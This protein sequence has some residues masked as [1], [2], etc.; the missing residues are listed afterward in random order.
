VSGFINTA[1]VPI[2]SKLDRSYIEFLRLNCPSRLLSPY[3]AWEDERDV[4]DAVGQF[5]AS[6]KRTASQKQFCPTGTRYRFWIIALCASMCLTSAAAHA[7]QISADD[8]APTVTKTPNQ[9]W[10]PDRTASTVVAPDLHIGISKLNG[11]EISGQLPPS[12]IDPKTYST[13][14]TNSPIASPRAFELDLYSSSRDLN[15]V[16]GESMTPRSFLSVVEAKYMI[17]ESGLGDTR[18]LTSVRGMA[19]YPLVEI[20]Y[21]EWHLPIGLYIPPLRGSDVR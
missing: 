9:W 3:Q 17:W 13:A 6:F 10:S 7:Q 21:A 18:S 15:L 8:F 14:Y 4:I 1:F 12:T 11:L 5:D 20:N 19:V 16:E 2:T